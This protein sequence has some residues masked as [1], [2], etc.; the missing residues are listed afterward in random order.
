MINQS[1]EFNSKIVNPELLVYNI[2]TSPISSYEE[3][4]ANDKT[5]IIVGSVFT[6]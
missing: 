5:N 2:F 1:Y 6:G 3:R 4:K